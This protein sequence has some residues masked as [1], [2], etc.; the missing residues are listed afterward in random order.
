MQIARAHEACL[1]WVGVYPAQLYE[2]FLVHEV[3]S[4][5]FVGR[6]AGVRGAPL[7][8]NQQGCDEKCVVDA[9]P[10]EETTSLN[11]APRV[12]RGEPDEVSA[13]IFGKEDGSDGLA[14]L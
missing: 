1:S 3:E 2:I 8:R 14:V 4:G 12:L 7:L 13:K 5:G 10:A 9:G 11:T 6:L